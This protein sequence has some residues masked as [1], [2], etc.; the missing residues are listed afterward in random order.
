M[1][2]YYCE[3]CEHLFK[4]LVKAN[5]M[6]TSETYE[7]RECGSH[8]VM[9]NHLNVIRLTLEPLMKWFDEH[10]Y[11]E[12]TKQP[13]PNNK[14]KW[15]VVNTHPPAQYLTADMWKNVDGMNK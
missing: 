1:K 5:Y 6:A 3:V 4:K 10:M 12:I 2:I 7:W 8:G 9:Q 13:R 15:H 14:S 11:W